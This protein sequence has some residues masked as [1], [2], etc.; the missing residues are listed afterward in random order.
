MPP[1]VLLS[2]LRE[3]TTTD[4]VFPLEN[5]VVILLQQEDADDKIKHTYVSTKGGFYWNI[6]C[7]ILTNAHFLTC[8]IY[9]EYSQNSLKFL[10]TEY[11][12]IEELF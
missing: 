6:G 1:T 10:H 7:K 2:F 12:I 5:V 9:V 3:L 11:S 4:S 8:D